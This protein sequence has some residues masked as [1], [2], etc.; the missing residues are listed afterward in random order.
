MKAPPEDSPL[1]NR[2][3]LGAMAGNAEVG[4]PVA[5]DTGPSAPT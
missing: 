2:V 4:P 3:A 1:A 5:F